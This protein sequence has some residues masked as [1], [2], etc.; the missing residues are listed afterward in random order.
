MRALWLMNH[1]TLRNFEVPLLRKYGFEIYLP[2]SFPY[3]EGNLSASITYEYDHDLTIPPSALEVLN[4]HD[5]YSGISS[6]VKDIINEYFD[7]AIFGFFP[8]QLAGLVRNF[9]GTLVMRP[10][11]LANGVKYEAVISATL[12]P[13]FL[14][15]IERIG[16]RFWFGQAYSSI[17]DEEQGVLKRRAIH[18]P[19][20]L[21]NAIRSKTWTGG[22]A[23][24]LFVCPR[25][26][27]SPYFNNIYRDFKSNFGD[28]P[29]YIGGLS[30]LRSM[31]EMF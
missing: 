1:T 6:Q 12:G 13:Y 23:K 21:A 4:A 9:T 19:L 14:W 26:Q 24:V 11:G 22:D 25:I 3:D 15:E 29:H 28:L 17:A 31:M 27:T 30:Q 2:K 7:I 10:F 20:G 5:F 18:L 16:E 8:D